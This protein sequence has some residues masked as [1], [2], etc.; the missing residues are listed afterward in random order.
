MRSA[1]IS[2]SSIARPRRLAATGCT[3]PVDPS[4]AGVILFDIGGSR[5]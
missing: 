3:P 5:G 2:R 1:S 4:A